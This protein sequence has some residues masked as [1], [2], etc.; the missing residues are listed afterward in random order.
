MLQPGMRVVIPF[1]PR[2]ITG[3]VVQRIEHSSYNQLK[4]IIDVLDLTPVLT[5]ELLK[6]GQRLSSE[7]LSLYITMFQAMLPQVLKAKYDKEIVR[8]TD[9]PLVSSLEQLFKIKEAVPFEEVVTALGNYRELQYYIEKG[10]LALR[11]VVTSRATKKY[12]TMILPRK[13]P[14]NKEALETLSKRATKQREILQF[15]INETHIIEKKEFYKRL[16]ISRQNLTP[17]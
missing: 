8:L 5:E 10:D 13:S 3:F 14:H 7:T 2:K 11:Y 16:D 9:H 6:L 4:E 12:K 17:L 15:F 1:G